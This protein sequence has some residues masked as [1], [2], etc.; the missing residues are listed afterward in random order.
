MPIRI[1]I[2]DLEPLFLQRCFI[3]ITI[4][5][6]ETT[7]LPKKDSRIAKPL[8]EISVAVVTSILR[9]CRLRPRRRVYTRVLQPITASPG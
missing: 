1:I 2:G 8:W 7:I 3:S 5:R 4:D 6:A 9:C